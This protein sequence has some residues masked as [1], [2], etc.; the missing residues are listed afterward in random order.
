MI[1][2]SGGIGEELEWNYNGAQFIFDNTSELPD[3]KL[4]TPVTAYVISRTNEPDGTSQYISQ[5]VIDMVMFDF[6]SITCTVKVGSV[7][8][9]TDSLFVQTSGKQKKLLG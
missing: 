4:T 7:S 1:T 9:E 3:A 2:C 5:L 6:V 8:T